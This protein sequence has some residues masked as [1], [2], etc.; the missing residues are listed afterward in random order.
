ME[1]KA[2]QTHWARMETAALI[3][4]VKE[5]TGTCDQACTGGNASTDHTAALNLAAFSSA[6][7]L[8]TWGPTGGSNPQEGMEA[9]RI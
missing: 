3:Y 5:F 8:G 9:S 2:R 4:W 6:G 1:S 7:Q